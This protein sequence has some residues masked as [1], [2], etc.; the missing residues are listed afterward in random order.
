MN[1]SVLHRVSLTACAVLFSAVWLGC[2]SAQVVDEPGEPNT[3][4]RTYDVRDLLNHPQSRSYFDPDTVEAGNPSPEQISEQ[5]R[6]VIA[7]ATSHHRGDGFAIKELDGTYR[8]TAGPARHDEIA[9]LLVQVRRGR[10]LQVSVESRYLRVP[11]SALKGLGLNMDDGGRFVDDPAFEALIDRVQRS[12]E[13]KFVNAPR[14][15]QFNGQTGYVMTVRRHAYVRALNLMGDRAAEAEKGVVDEGLVV[16]YQPVVSADRKHVTLVLRARDTELLKIV[17]TPPVARIDG[18][19]VWTQR[20]VT[21]VADWQTTVSVPDN[22]TLLLKAD[23][24]KHDAEVLNAEP[25]VYL[26]AI[27]PR[28]VV[29]TAALD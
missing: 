22:A 27:K 8:I 10:E 15:T 14:I 23:T 11:T 13:S 18:R 1:G 12:S 2:E 25:M 28:I 7:E 4:A 6:H 19:R 26:L 29:Q 17:D 16:E 9:R 21:T 24:V 20:P 3:L 5:L